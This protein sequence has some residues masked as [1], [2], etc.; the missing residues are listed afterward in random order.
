MLGFKYHYIVRPHELIFSTQISPLNST[1]HMQLPSSS[2]FGFLHDISDSV[3]LKHKLQTPTSRKASSHHLFYL[4]D[5]LCHPSRYSCKTLDIILFIT[6]YNQSSE[7]SI[8]SPYLQNTSKE[9]P[10]QLY[11]DHPGPN[12]IISCLAYYNSFTCYLCF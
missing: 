4:I 5:R 7:K 12:G 11:H 1:M 3:C 9:T 8:F 2:P 6:S 10:Y